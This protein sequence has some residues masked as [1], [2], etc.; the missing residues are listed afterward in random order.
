M[1]LRPN[2]IITT[3][4]DFSKS[5]TGVDQLSASSLLVSGVLAGYQAVSSWLAAAPQG[6]HGVT[7]AACDSLPAT[8]TPSLAL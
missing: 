2:A 1:S 3:P 7:R 5:D 8:P 6:L 4:G